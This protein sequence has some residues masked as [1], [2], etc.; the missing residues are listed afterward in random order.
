[1]YPSRCRGLAP[2]GHQRTA[3]RRHP[4]PAGPQPMS[5]K[6]MP[7]F[8]RS[9]HR[10]AVAI[11]TLDRPQTFNAWHRPMR[12]E[13][14]VDLRAAEAAAAVR[15]MILPGAGSAAFSAGQDLAESMEFDPDRAEEWIVEWEQ[16]YDLIRSLSKPIIAALNGV[17][18]GSAF[19]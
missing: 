5:R 2:V 17:A 18:A 12:E 1:V 19:Q 11:I 8:I 16:L 13:L 4:R 15:A 7:E 10:D 14:M 9:E 3:T 6:I